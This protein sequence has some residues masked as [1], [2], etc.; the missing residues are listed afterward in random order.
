[1][2]IDVEAE[3]R[4]LRLWDAEAPDAAALASDQPFAIDTLTLPQW[5]QFIFL[6]NMYRLIEDDAELPQRCGIVPM[7]EEFFRGTRLDL[8]RLLTALGQID[9]LLSDGQ[10]D[11]GV[12]S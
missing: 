12:D 6:P 9:V 4:R 2:L 11:Y 3:L 7:A 10:P 1:M 8:D 5:L